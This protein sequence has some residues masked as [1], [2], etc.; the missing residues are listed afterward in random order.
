LNVEVT[1]PLVSV[2]V[3]IFFTTWDHQEMD[4]EKENMPSLFLGLLAA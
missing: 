3:T 1:N 2:K 4:E